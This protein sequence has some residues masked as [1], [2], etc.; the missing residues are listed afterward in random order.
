[1]EF[2]QLMEKYSK[3]MVE[4]TEEMEPAFKAY[5]KEKRKIHSNIVERLIAF[6]MFASYLID[7]GILKENKENEPIMFLYLRSSLSLLGIHS[8]LKNGLVTEGAILLRSIFELY[9]NLKLILEKDTESRIML[10]SEYRH[11]ESWLKLKS[12]RKLLQ[13]DLISQERFDMTFTV[14]ETEMIDAKYESIKVNYHPKIPYHWAWKIFKSG[15]K[16]INPS[17]KSICVHF[18]MKKEYDDVYSTMSIVVHSSTLVDNFMKLN[19]RKTLV[20]TFNENIKSIGVNGLDLAGRILS[21]VVDYFNIDEGEDLK[22]FTNAYVLV[23]IK[24]AGIIK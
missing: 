5:V 12:K 17:I 1:M 19:G 15:K 3:E 8:C 13:E 20:P 24:E 16:N 21:E 10:Y 6:Y 9:V 23:A 7:E 22:K 4:Y 2:E 11:I 18:G 14:E